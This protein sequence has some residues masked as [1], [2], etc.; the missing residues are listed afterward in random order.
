MWIVLMGNSSP[1]VAPVQV[2]DSIASCYNQA[3]KKAGESDAR[4]PALTRSRRLV[5][6]ELAEAVL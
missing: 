2:E 1:E 5:L 6:V 4:G 3:A